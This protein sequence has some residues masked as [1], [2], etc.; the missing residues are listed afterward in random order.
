MYS[1]KIGR[2]VCFARLEQTT[3][4]AYSGHKFRAP[5]FLSPTLTSDLDYPIKNLIDLIPE[6][7]IRLADW[8][9]VQGLGSALCTGVLY[10]CDSVLPLAQVAGH[11]LISCLTGN[12]HSTAVCP[13]MVS[14]T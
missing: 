8:S 4:R 13:S 10:L 1:L 3:K 7:M 2:E 5:S 14:L 9:Q 12:F 6:L 11:T